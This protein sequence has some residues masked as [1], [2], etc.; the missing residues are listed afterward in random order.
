MLKPGS[1]VFVDG[2]WVEFGGDGEKVP[3]IHCHRMLTFETVEA[4]RIVPGSKGGTY[5]RTNVQPSCRQ[6]NA[7]RNDNEEWTYATHRAPKLDV[8]VLVDEVIE[9]ILDTMVDTRSVAA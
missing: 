2:T 3:C 8:A 1:G 6:C 7:S 5:R 4:D 9:K